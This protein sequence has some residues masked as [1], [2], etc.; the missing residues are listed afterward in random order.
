MRIK[1]LY[2][3]AFN[4]DPTS[5]INGIVIKHA[6]CGSKISCS[7]NAYDIMD[8]IKRHRCP[9]SESEIKNPEWFTGRGNL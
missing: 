2:L 3:D 8:L 4:I 7:N 5:Y 6:T 1:N 9:K